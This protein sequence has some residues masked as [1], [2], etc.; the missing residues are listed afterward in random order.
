MNIFNIP[1]YRAKK[2]NSEEY[3]TGLL[4]E[5]RQS[6]GTHL[7]YRIPVL[8]YEIDPTTL[9]INFPD[10]QDSEN[11]PIFASLSEL[12]K[13]GD[14]LSGTTKYQKIEKEFTCFCAER[15]IIAPF[16]YSESFE[17][18]PYRDYYNEFKIIGI[19]K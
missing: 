8:G 1:I 10:M 18:K 5:K 14:R 19:Q 6:D 16:T 4:D 12:G 9:S 13:G 7:Y 2:I 3:V 11:T 15:G 17:N